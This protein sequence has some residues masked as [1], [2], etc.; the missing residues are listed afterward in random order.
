[1][2]ES[3]R[4]VRLL[5]DLELHNHSMQNQSAIII[6]RLVTVS[7]I[8]HFTLVAGHILQNMWVIVENRVVI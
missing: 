5:T 7:D 3:Q 4:S 6:I 1:M 8:T 2:I